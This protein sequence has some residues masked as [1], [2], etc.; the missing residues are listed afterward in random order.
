[1]QNSTEAAREQDNKTGYCKYCGRPLKNY[2]SII[3]DAGDVCLARYKRSR[4]RRI[5]TTGGINDG[6]DKPDTDSDKE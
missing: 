4:V 3:R 5:S 2:G 1:M 6:S